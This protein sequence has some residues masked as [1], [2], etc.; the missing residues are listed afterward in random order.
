MSSLRSLSELYQYKKSDICVFLG[1]GPSINKI[2]SKEWVAIK[3]CDIWTINNWIY[4]PFIVPDFYHVEVKKYNYDILKRRFEEKH[5]IYR[6]VKFLFRMK[7]KSGSNAAV[8]G[9]M[10]YK[11]GY[12]LKNR[13]QKR[14]MPVF[15]ADYKI[16]KDILT[17][18]HCISITLLLELIYKM[19]YQMVVFYGVDLYDS[20]YFWTGG[21]SIYG[22]VHHQTNKEHENKD[23][24]SPH[25]TY[26]IKDFIVDFHR[27]W[28]APGKRRFVVGHKN[29]LLFPELEYVDICS[30][31][32]MDKK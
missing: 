5:E 20:R 13:D 27:R 22:E 7:K 31:N 19:G 4:H 9:N 16:N 12:S 2:S 24:N 29:T 15:N 25:T 3:K 17:K 8:V 14:K 32:I 28:M 6:N 10:P 21:N 30:M 11:F 18:S 23:P 1:S 26:K